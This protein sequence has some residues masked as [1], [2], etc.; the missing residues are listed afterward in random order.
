MVKQVAYCNT[1]LD[2]FSKTQNFFVTLGF[3]ASALYAT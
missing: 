1:E 2:Y 3:V